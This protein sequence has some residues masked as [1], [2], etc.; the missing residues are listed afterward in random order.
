MDH[1]FGVHGHPSIGCLLLQKDIRILLVH[2]K[3]PCMYL[4]DVLQHVQHSMIYGDWIWIHENGS[5]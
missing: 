3:I 2:M 4:V 5:D 1:C